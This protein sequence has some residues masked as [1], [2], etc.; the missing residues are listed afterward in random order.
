MTK[1]G[2]KWD[3]SGVLN[4]RQ[5]DIHQVNGIILDAE[6]SSSMI[7]SLKKNLKKLDYVKG[8]EL[9]FWHGFIRQ[10]NLVK[11]VNNSLG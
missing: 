6:V 2:D 7:G 5:V 1:R 4:G 10:Q 3:I 8:T 11:E 9:N